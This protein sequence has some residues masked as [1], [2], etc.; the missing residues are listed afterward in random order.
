M[1]VSLKFRIR[2]NNVLEGYY[3]EG[4]GK[5]MIPCCIYGKHKV[6]KMP[7]YSIYQDYTC[8]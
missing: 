3:S 4:K 7:D 5:K 2:A 6:L 8:T 1:I